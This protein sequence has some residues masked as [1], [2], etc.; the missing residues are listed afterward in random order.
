M[1]NYS[2]RTKIN[3]LL[4][5]IALVVIVSAGVYLSDSKAKD[6][7]NLSQAQTLATALEKYYYKY[8]RYPTS[9]R[10]GADAV[11]LITENGINQPGK[12]VYYR[13]SDYFAKE[14]TLASTGEAYFLEFSMAN[15]WP[16]WGAE[17][18]S[19]CRVKNGL[20]LECQKTK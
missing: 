18:D 10:L 5:L 8:Q 4:L 17:R 11:Q 13:Q 3:L 2:L 9:P 15:K 7:T 19:V 16:S 14:T 1:F 6:L 20:K 12:V